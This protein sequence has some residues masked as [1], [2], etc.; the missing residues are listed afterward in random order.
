M[1]FMSLNLRGIGGSL[2]AASFRRAL[3]T[4]HPNIVFLQE[5]MVHEQKARS[6]MH[7][8]RPSWVTCAVSSVGLRV[9]FWYRGIHIFLVWFHTLLVA[10]FC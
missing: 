6:Y 7:K 2:K 4:T 3:E 10:G 9:V 1:I 8:F 5:T